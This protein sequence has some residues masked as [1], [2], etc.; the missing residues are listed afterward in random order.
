LRAPSEEK[1][2]DSKESICEELEQLFFHFPR[3]HMN[4]LLGE[5]IEK[6]GREDN[7]KPTIGN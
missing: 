5:L 6:L 3:Y 1:I 2:E 7:F 4:N